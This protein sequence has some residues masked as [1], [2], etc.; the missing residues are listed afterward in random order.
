[1]A[2]AD[3]GQIAQF[4]AALAS[5]LSELDLRTWVVDYLRWID[6]G[7]D[8][9]TQLLRV[10]DAALWEGEPHPGQAPG[11]AQIDTGTLRI[12]SR[13]V[14]FAGMS[15]HRVVR[16]PR[17]AT[18][19]YGEEVLSL[20]AEESSRIWHFADLTRANAFLGAVLL[21]IADNFVNDEQPALDRVPEHD[22]ETYI[23]AFDEQEVAPAR[24]Q[25]ARSATD[26]ET[27]RRINGLS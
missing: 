10:E 7:T 15:Q 11:L 13:R 8:N 25:V 6:W 5:K 20:G 12:T 4:D 22:I 27:L 3:R 24:A 23:A 19:S 16:F 1:V 17:L 18:W 2:K 26:A 14:I 21:N 9:E